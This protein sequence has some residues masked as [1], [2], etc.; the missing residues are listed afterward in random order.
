[1]IC[2]VDRWHITWTCCARKSTESAVH[3]CRQY[4]CNGLFM[5]RPVRNNQF[6]I[7]HLE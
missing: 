2:L 1:M 3:S 7:P 6:I 4:H 5:L